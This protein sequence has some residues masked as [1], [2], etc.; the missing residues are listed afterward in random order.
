M[1]EIFKGMDNA[2]DKINENF[3]GIKDYIIDQ[4]ENSKGWWEKWASGKLVQYGA[5]LKTHS[6]ATEAWGSIYL[7]EPVSIEYP[8]AFWDVYSLEVSLKIF[9]GF[10][11]WL[12]QYDTRTHNPLTETPRYALARPRPGAGVTNAEYHFIAIGRWKKPD[13]WN[14]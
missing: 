13:Y 4:G 12:T 14:D 11:G 10:A 2:A 3:K 5:L 9:D 1:N 6:G 8:I 7:S